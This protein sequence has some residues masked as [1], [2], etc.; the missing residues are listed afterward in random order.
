MMG[1]NE[2]IRGQMVGKDS[3]VFIRTNVQRT[4]R[5]ISIKTFQESSNLT[6][7][8][9]FCVS[10]ATTDLGLLFKVTNSVVDFW[11]QAYKAAYFASLMY[12]SRDLL[13]MIV[14]H[15]QFN[16]I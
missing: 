9:R 13:P 4:L 7:S 10:K 15:G 3:L 5:K 6:F 2:I 16:L 12:A 1:K 11:V 14:K 8:E